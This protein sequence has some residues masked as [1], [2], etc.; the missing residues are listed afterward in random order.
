M[1]NITLVRADALFAPMFLFEIAEAETLNRQLL[2]E[3]MA[4]R[5]QS[6]GVQ[7]SNASVWHSKTDFFRRAEPGRAALRAF[8]VEAIREATLKLLPGFDF[9]A[10][11]TQAHGWFNVNP[12]GAS[13]K[14]HS[15]LGFTPSGTYWAKIPSNAP[16]SS[17][18]FEFIDPRIYTNREP[19]DGATFQSHCHLAPK[20]GR[21]SVF[22]SYL[23]H[24]LYPNE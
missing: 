16:N 24:S 13:N 23:R 11:E 12:H 9:N 22:P 19:L 20:A 15:H 14:P 6:P 8:I 1:S 7:R 18:A 21:L 5:A 17:G 10:H 3:L 2:E 4:M